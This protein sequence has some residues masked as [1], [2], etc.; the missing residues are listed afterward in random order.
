MTKSMTTSE[1]GKVY[2][3][4]LER[5]AVADNSNIVVLSHGGGKLSPLYQSRSIKQTRL[6]RKGVPRPFSGQSC[7]YAHIYIYYNTSINFIKT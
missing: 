6:S 7:L 2:M 3:A 5:C 1:R 4:N